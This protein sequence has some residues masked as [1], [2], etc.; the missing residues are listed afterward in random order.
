MT[1]DEAVITSI[2]HSAWLNVVLWVATVLGALGV[3]AWVLLGGP[4]SE[5]EARAAAAERLWSI[6]GPLVLGL[7]AKSKITGDQKT[8]VVQARALVRAP[9]RAARR[10]TDF[11]PPPEALGHGR[12]SGGSTG[13]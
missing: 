2:E 7:V 5:A 13:K 11:V 8:A 1:E 10:S 6:F 4:S 3:V 9:P 12:R